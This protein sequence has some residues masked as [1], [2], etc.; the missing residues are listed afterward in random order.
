VTPRAILLEL[1]GLASVWRDAAL[2]AR[3]PV[4]PDAGAK[5]TAERKLT[6][7]LAG[8]FARLNQKAQAK[9]RANLPT[10]KA[11]AEWWDEDEFWEDDE[12]FAG[13]LAILLAA[14]QLGALSL[15]AM[16]GLE[17]D[18]SATN[19]EAAE[20]AR[21]YTFELVKGLTETSRDALRDVI[22]AF[23]E[24]PGMTIGDVIER[25]PFDEQR[26]ALIATTEITRAYATGQAAAGDAMKE[27]FP[28]VRVVKTWF[29][30]NDDRVCPICGPLNGEE[31]DED[32]D[33]GGEFDGPPG[34]PG[35]R[36]W[37]SY[38]TRING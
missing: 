31:V 14:Q 12:F 26:A 1:L 32:E 13:M 22:S 6:A 38:R 8:Y 10:Q 21:A 11:A 19:K 15:S 27:Q 7:L 3:R 35:C 30:N 25:L 23:V 33:F 4:E 34:H 16:L 17:L 29:T 2:K 24:T 37:V 36:C 20:A 18:L 5:L 9:L 28:D